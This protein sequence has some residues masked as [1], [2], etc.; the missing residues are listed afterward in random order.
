MNMDIQ[1]FCIAILYQ[2]IT[3]GTILSC[4]DTTLF[5]TGAHINEISITNQITTT[6]LAVT[7]TTNT[8][9]RSSNRCIVIEVIRACS[10]CE[11]AVI[12]AVLAA[13]AVLAFNTDLTR[14][15]G[16]ILHNT[17]ISFSTH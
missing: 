13:R 4:T 8:R 7:Y 6:R 15:G 3:I 2:G 11:L 16:I 9:S 17:T 5:S 1:L 14:T 10:T 12:G